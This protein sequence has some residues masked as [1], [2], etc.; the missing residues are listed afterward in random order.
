MPRKAAVHIEGPVRL[1]QRGRH[2]HAHYTAEGK[3]VRQSLKVTNLKDAQPKAREIGALLERGE[4]A[5]LQ[6]LKAQKGK[7]FAEFLEE[8]EEKF[9]G[10]GENTWKATRAIRACLVEEWGDLPVS[11]VSARMI[12]AFLA[13]RRDQYGITNATSN[14]YLACIKT[15]FKMAVRWGV[16]AH[17][18][19]DQVKMLKEDPKVPEALSEAQIEA[20]LEE[21]PDYARVVVKLGVDTGM[22]RGEMQRLQWT[23]VD[24]ERHF[25]TVRQSKNNEFRV[26]PMSKRVHSTLTEQ[27]KKGLI[28][29]VLVGPDNTP[30]VDLKKCLHS[31]G[32]RAG[33]GHVHLHMCRHAFATRLRERGVAIDRIMELL[34]HKTMAMA[35]RYAKATPT[36][37][38]DAIAALDR[39]AARR[40][41][42]A[43][44]AE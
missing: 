17:N 15:A 7:T 24:F 39:P 41:L 37:L 8:F 32:V 30:F 6:E 44:W 43:S 29:F 36:Q 21:L 14:R 22:R 1:V 38:E 28:P 5:R 3:R 20:L 2:W 4:Y 19:A 27:K 11:Q 35:L 10:W 16:A 40:D 18:P 23:D 26:I 12:E 13:K 25:I 9:G 34:G 31:A 42:E 33:C